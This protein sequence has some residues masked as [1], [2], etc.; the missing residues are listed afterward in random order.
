[1]RTF[2]LAAAVAVTLT[3]VGGSVARASVSNSSADVVVAI[4]IVKNQDLR[5]G[6]MLS[7]STPGTVV[8]TTGGV[9]QAA[10]GVV[11]VPPDDHGPAI[12]FVT[13]HA[14]NG[15]SIV[16][17]AGAIS[18][19]SGLNTMTVD[20]FTSTPSG[21]GILSGA[22]EQTVHVGATLHVGANQPPGTYTQS[23]DVTVAYN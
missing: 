1:M 5:F 15:Y 6:R 9:L 13:G 20:G 18:L 14:G 17:P 16:L 23:F 22:G 7:G 8:I 10:G 12:F 3:G 4:A 2:M 11:P 19:E 21:V